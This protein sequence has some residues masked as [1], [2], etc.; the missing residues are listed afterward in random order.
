VKKHKRHNSNDTSQSAK[1]S[2]TTV[3]T[4]AALKLTPKAVSTRNFFAPLKKSGRPSPTVMNS[5]TYLIALQSDLKE[6][7]KGEYEFRNT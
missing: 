2:S 5:T 7:V 4:F 1:K 6:H 3:T